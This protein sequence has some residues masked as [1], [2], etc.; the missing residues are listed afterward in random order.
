MARTVP[1]WI[2][3]TNDTPVP[4]RV[5]MRVFIRNG[6]RCQCG[7]G[8]KIRPGDKW[9]TDHAT[10]VINGGP[11]RESNLRTLLDGRE[12]HGKKTRKDVAQ[13][14]TNY[15]VM[16]KHFGLKSRRHSS[17]SCGKDTPFKKKLTGEVVKR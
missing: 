6:G 4:D 1:E 15:R 7:C 3:K 12:H 10:A 17:W 8:I 2:G 9:E 14:A 5:R 11:N 16:K 13:K